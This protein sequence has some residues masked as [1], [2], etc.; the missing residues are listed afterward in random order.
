MA[1]VQPIEQR[2]SRSFETEF[3]TPDAARPR[4]DSIDLL[5]GLVMVLMAL[6]HTRG[7]FT[8]AHFDPTDLSKTTAALFLTRW[9]THF[10]APVFTFLAG[11]GAYLAAARGKTRPQL[12]R[13]LL[14][15]GLWLIVLEYTV[16]WFGITFNFDWHFIPASVLWALGWG[17]I[18]LAGLVHLPLPIIAAFA[19]VTIAGH[20]LFDAVRPDQLGPLGPLWAVLH[21][22]GPLLLTPSVTMF[23]RYPLVPWIGVMAAGYVFGAVFLLNRPRR[24]TTLLGLGA[25]LVL[26]FVALRAVNFYGDPHPWSPRQDALFTVL[27]FL[28]CQKYPPSLLYLLMTLGPALLALSVFERGLG[29]LARPLLMFGRVPLFFYLLQWYAAHLLAIVVNAALG[30]PASWLFGGAPWNAPKGYGYSLGVVYL[31]WIVVLILLYLPC[32]WFAALKRR[33]R[34]AWLGYF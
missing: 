21:T 29:R 27:S 31:M 2:T 3:A 1:A 15:R 23:V 4:L 7:F 18:V 17:M 16:V 6:D 11:A 13:F 12:S 10:C 25:S 22:R 30:R 34:E 5:R 14:T 8:N 9:I 26:L 28:N 24:R 20:N 33:R 32:R 19:V